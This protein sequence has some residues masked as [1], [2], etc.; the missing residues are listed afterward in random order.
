M[1]TIQR[2]Y[3]NEG[4]TKE[5]ESEL[6][7]IGWFVMNE[8]EYLDIQFE[9]TYLKKD[10]DR[11]SMNVQFTADLERKACYLTL[12]NNQGDGFNS[13]VDINL[14]NLDLLASLDQV[15]GK[16]LN[17]DQEQVHLPVSKALQLIR[18]NPKSYEAIRT[19]GVMKLESWL[20]AEQ[21]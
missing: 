17:A 16:L 18:Q 19:D 14:K 4:I 21:A 3:L 13:L 7:K 5:Q 20:K 1:N 9:T 6:G 12:G 10:N 11:L 2:I 15:I 8:G